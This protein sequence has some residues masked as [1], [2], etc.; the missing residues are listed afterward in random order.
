M[1]TLEQIFNAIAKTPPHAVMI[2]VC[3]IGLALLFILI[4]QARNNR[5]SSLKHHRSDGPGVADLLNWAA[6]IDDG[7]ILN[8]N[9]SLMAAWIYRGNDN[10]SATNADRNAVS[11]F[12]NAA[13]NQLGSGWM[14]HIDA[15]RRSCPTY[16]DPAASHFPDPV[17]AALDQERR[18]Y[19]SRIQALYE[20]CFVLTAT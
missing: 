12:L 6:V 15:I 16:S 18:E 19:F 13:L 9:G 11:R 2:A 17:S 3:V 20:G 7:V 10:A 4:A 1:E 5:F 14:F 8:K